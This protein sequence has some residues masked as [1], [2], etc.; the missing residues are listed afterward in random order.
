[1]QKQL[2][3]NDKNETELQCKESQK[4]ILHVTV[5]RSIHFLQSILKQFLSQSCHFNK[6][7]CLRPL[8]DKMRC[9]LITASQTDAF[10][11]G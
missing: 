9:V 8:T 3:M 1:M 4:F 11:S 10:H 7:I 2:M 6:C 5:S